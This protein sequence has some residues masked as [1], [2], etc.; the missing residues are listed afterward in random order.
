[1]RPAA[2]SV[3]AHWPIRLTP[4]DLSSATAA[5]RRAA[6]AAGLRRCTVRRPSSVNFS[7]NKPYISCWI[8]EYSDF[9]R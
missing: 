5:K 6:G 2:F 3:R 4:L 7:S 9:H 8:E 1:M